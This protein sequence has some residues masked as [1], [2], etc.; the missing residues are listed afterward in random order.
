MTLPNLNFDMRQ[1][2]VVVAT[3]ADEESVLAA[4]EDAFDA[5]GGDLFSVVHTAANVLV[6][7][8]ALAALSAVRFIFWAGVAPHANALAG[9]IS[10][11]TAI[12]GGV[13]VNVN[14]DAP[15][16]ACNL[17]S[18]YTGVG[19][20]FTGLGLICYAGRNPNRVR[21]VPSEETVTLHFSDTIDPDDC[22]MAHMGA[23]FTPRSAGYVDSADS[24]GHSRL[25][26]MCTAGSQPL[27]AWMW[28]QTPTAATGFAVGGSGTTDTRILLVAPGETTYTNLD[29]D[30]ATLDSTSSVNASHWE[31]P[32]GKRVLQT[33]PLSLYASP[34]NKVATLRQAFAGFGVHGEVEQ[35]PGDPSPTDKFMLLGAQRGLA[36]QA[37][38]L[39]N[40]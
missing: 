40:P 2:E 14:Q 38:V 25:W 27:S 17:G 30:W 20:R 35:I 33:I 5:L 39:V 15:D 32:D 18:P 26:G 12:Y 37:F 24:D 31:T 34:Y 9:V 29:R 6:V 13:A 28:N 11:A 21:I 22:A 4:V 1:S 3:P 7:K 36:T 10:S 16:Q 23:I 19:D 8:P